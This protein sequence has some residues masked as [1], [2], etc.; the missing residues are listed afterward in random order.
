[1]TCLASIFLLNSGQSFRGHDE[2]EI[3]CIKVSFGVGKLLEQVNE[4]LQNL[5]LEMS[6]CGFK[7]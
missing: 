3:P 7:T 6:W 1:M 2:Y 5:T 4:S